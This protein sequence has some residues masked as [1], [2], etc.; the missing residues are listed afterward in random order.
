MEKSERNDYRKMLSVA[1]SEFEE[2]WRYCS[3]SDKAC[4]SLHFR[5]CK[6]LGKY[7]K[8]HS[9]GTRKDINNYYGRK[10]VLEILGHRSEKDQLRTALEAKDEKLRLT[11]ILIAAMLRNVPKR[12]KT[13]ISYCADIVKLIDNPLLPETEVTNDR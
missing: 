6:L 4:K 3:F 5:I 1:S 2:M 9:A 13:A 10:E 12:N 7:N 8:T 11:K